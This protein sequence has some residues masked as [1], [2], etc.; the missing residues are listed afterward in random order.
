LVHLPLDDLELSA[1]QEN[2][3]VFGLVRLATKQNKFEQQ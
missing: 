2:L 3:Q 1:Q